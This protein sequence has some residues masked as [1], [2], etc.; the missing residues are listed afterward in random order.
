MFWVLELISTGIQSEYNRNEHCIL[1]LV[2]DIPNL[3]TVNLYLLMQLS[4]HN[5][6]VVQGLLIFLVTVAKKP[7]FLGLK[8]KATTLVSQASGVYP[9]ETGMSDVSMSEGTEMRSLPPK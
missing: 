6:H 9:R 2:L 1:L 8:E 7:V 4:V 5:A 3:L